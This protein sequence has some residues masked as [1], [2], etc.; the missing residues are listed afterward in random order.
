MK[1]WCK[2][3]GHEGKNNEE[4]RIRI[5][6]YPNIRINMEHGTWSSFDALIYHT[7]DRWVLVSERQTPEPY[8]MMYSNMY[9]WTV[10]KFRY[11]TKNVFYD[12]FTMSSWTAECGFLMFWS[13]KFNKMSWWAIKLLLNLFEQFLLFRMNTLYDD[14]TRVLIQFCIMG[15]WGKL[16]PQWNQPNIQLNIISMHWWISTSYSNKCLP[17]FKKS[18]N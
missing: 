4:W 18:V 6:E 2:S 1:N 10:L 17:R 14:D 12:L 5:S 8:S 3:V 11:S 7:P 9:K 16:I 15:K 13:L